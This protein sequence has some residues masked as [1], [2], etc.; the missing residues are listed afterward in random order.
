MCIFF[1]QAGNQVIKIVRNPDDETSASDLVISEGGNYA[2]NDTEE[3][4]NDAEKSEETETL[5]VNVQGR[6]GKLS[7]F[8]N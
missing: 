4:I 3:P 2:W 8:L 7:Q 6:N 5:I 1:H